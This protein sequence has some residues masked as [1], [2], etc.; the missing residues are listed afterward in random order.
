MDEKIWEEIVEAL[1]RLQISAD[2]EQA[3]AKAEA[4]AAAA[5]IARNAVDEL[6][7]T[8]LGKS[9]EEAVRD[10]MYPQRWA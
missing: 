9:T 10:N 2:R 5:E 3:K 4:K 6:W 8:E 7:S 1:V